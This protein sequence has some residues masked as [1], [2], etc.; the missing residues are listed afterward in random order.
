[1]AV[2]GIEKIFGDDVGSHLKA[3]H[4]AIELT[5]HPRA[6]EAASRPQ[7][8]RRQAAGLLQ[9]RQNPLLNAPGLGIGE[10]AAAVVAEIGPPCPADEGGL[11]VDELAVGAAALLQDAPF[12][13][14]KG[15][16]PAAVFED[17]IL[18]S[19]V[20]CSLGRPSIYAH[21]QQ[22]QE[23]YFVDI[24]HQLGPRM[25]RSSFHRFTFTRQR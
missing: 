24:L 17:G 19:L 20:G 1:M 23:T 5:P 3:R 10:N 12:P 9:C 8:A 11:A 4:I 15:P 13:C 25:Y 21:R 7:F 14:P 22:W 2:A 16:L 6:V 18:R